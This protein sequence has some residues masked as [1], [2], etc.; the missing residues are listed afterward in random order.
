MRRRE[1][2][3]REWSVI[4]PR[5]PRTS[6]GIARVDDRKVINGILWRFRTGSSWRDVPAMGRERHYNR[7]TRWRAAGVRD[8]FWPQL[9]KLTMETSI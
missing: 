9:R 7:F 2:S 6:R 3:G 8:A 4:E 1:L 5:F